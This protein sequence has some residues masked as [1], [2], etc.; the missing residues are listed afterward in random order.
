MFG[1]LVSH[2]HLDAE[3]TFTYAYAYLD[4]QAFDIAVAEDNPPEPFTGGLYESDP[5]Q[6]VVR[7][8]ADPEPLLAALE[9]H[10]HPAVASVGGAAS[11]TEPADP[12]EPVPGNCLRS[13]SGLLSAIAEGIEVE[14]AGIAT[15]TTTLQNN[16]GC[17]AGVTTQTN[18]PSEPS[19]SP[20]VVTNGPIESGACTA[21]CV[22][23]RSVT[24]VQTRDYTIL[25]ANCDT[26]NCSESRVRTRNQ[27]ANGP[28]FSTAPSCTGAMSSC[29]AGGPPVA[30]CEFG[31]FYDVLGLGWSSWSNGGC[32]VANY[33]Q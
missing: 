12:A 11:G 29:G 13:V 25:C 7:A 23:S 28:N 5:L 8:L 2:L 22:Y 20:W 21:Y 32:T 4:A 24:S 33:C 30:N 15:F 31:F 18:P 26:H 10:G 14:E 19:C 3:D 27:V 16:C 17:V 6:P 1:H 9:S